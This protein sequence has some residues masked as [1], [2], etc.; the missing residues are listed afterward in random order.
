M[1]YTLFI[2]LCLFTAIYSCD[3]N[4]NANRDADP[5]IHL[6]TLFPAPTP[7]T[8][9]KNINDRVTVIADSGEFYIDCRIL[10]KADTA[11]L[12]GTKV[13]RSNLTEWVNAT[14]YKRYH[15]SFSVIQGI[16]IDAYKIRIGEGRLSK[17]VWLSGKNIY[18]APW[19]NIDTLKQGDSVIIQRFG[20]FEPYKGV[21][22]QDVKE[23][24]D[25]VLIKYNEYNGSDAFNFDE[26]F[27][28]KYPA[29]LADIHPGAIMYFDKMYWV[30]ILGTRDDTHIIVRQ[31]GFPAKDMI[32]PIS[33]LEVY[34]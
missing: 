6:D 2:A 5:I 3:V 10:D 18:P 26:V 31:S 30:M 14:D 1:R 25:Y 29:Q 21:L 20:D 7:P 19:I 13:G 4:P 32:V 23:H 12:I 17:I 33:K 27:I 24:T 34:K 8:F 11:Y 16:I 9:V 22:T 28:Q 15:S